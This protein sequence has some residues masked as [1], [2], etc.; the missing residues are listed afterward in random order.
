[1]PGAA[2]PFC[3]GGRDVG[4]C[5]RAIEELYQVCCL[6]AVRQ[7]L[8]ECL[9]YPGS[10]EPPEPLPY[11]VPFA[12]LARKRPPADAVDSEVVDRFQEF[13]VVVPWL[14]PARL[15]CIEYLQRDRPIPL[16][17][18]RQH[19]RLPVAGHL[20]IRIT[21][22]SGIPPDRAPANRPHRLALQLRTLGMS[23]SMGDHDWGIMGCLAHRSRRRWSSGCRR[24]GM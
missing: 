5:S 6:A 8:E 15:R 22:D 7:N 24:C 21:P 2:A 17:H 12:I 4:A 9:E 3:P 23:E 18:P 11:A 20:L 14:S 13:T 19:G 1:M 16:R 10:A